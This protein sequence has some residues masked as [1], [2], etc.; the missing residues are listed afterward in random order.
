MLT[1]AT[2]ALAQDA[3]AADLTIHA[4]EMNR[5]EEELL[6]KLI[7]RL[8]AQAAGELTEGGSP[9]RLLKVILPDGTPH[10]IKLLV[11]LPGAV[12]GHDL[13]SFRL[14]IQQIDK[15][16][17][18]N[19][20]LRRFYTDKTHEF[21]G[22]DWAAYTMPFYPNED[23][24]ACLRTDEPRPDLFYRRLGEVL[25]LLITDGY[26]KDRA[27]TGSGN[28][29]GVHADRLDR[30]FWLLA[31]YL[32]TSMTEPDR[33]VVNGRSCRHPLQLARLI[34]TRPELTA[35]VDPRWLYYPVHG[36]LNTRNILITPAEGIIQAD[37]EGVRIIDPRGT[38]DPWDI[39]YDVAKVLFSLSVWDGGLRKG[40]EITQPGPDESAFDLR[41]RGQPY[42][43]YVAAAHSF[44]DFLTNHAEFA[45]LSAEDPGWRDRLLLGHAFHLLAEAACRLSDIKKRTNELTDSD[46][47]PL[48]LAAGHYL[49]GVLFLEDAV[50]QLESNGAVDPQTH[51]GLLPRAS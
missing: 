44:L 7:G 30:R 29:A 15:V 35:S 2:T 39:S 32:P 6:A 17:A 50:A 18:E 10:V 28:V 12:D 16:R 38:L 43:G 1:Q 40:F 51:L 13:E 47:S 14:K 11:D 8:D 4:E 34:L 37:P 46:I 33:I 42:P 31:K 22:P 26:R 25:R 19:P 20:D 27:A 45:E 21:H 48:E 23:I 49:Y 36:D 5:Y 3:P 24:A 41:F 9:A